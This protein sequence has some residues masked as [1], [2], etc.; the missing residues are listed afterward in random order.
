MVMRDRLEAAQV[1]LSSTNEWGSDL[2]C[3]RLITR[4]TLLNCRVLG[5]GNGT[6]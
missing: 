2:A 4:V 5:D 3:K 6:I 1:E